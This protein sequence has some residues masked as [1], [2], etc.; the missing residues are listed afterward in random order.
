MEEENQKLKMF[1]LKNRYRSIVLIDFLSLFF[2]GCYRLLKE[3]EESMQLIEDQLQKQEMI[4]VCFY[5]LL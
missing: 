2:W 1:V 3:K 5:F 4:G